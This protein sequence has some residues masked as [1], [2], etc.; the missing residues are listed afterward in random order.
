[1][2]PSRRLECETL[3][4]WLHHRNPTIVTDKLPGMI[5]RTNKQ[6]LTTKPKPTSFTQKLLLPTTHLATMASNPQ[7]LSELEKDPR[8]FLYTSLT[9]GSSHIVTATSRIETILRANR[10]PFAYIDTATNEKA[11]RLWVRRAG[12]RKLPALVKDG[13]VIGV[14]ELPLDNILL[15]DYTDA[16][17]MVGSRP[18]RR[19][20]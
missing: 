20:E 18:S 16:G 6:L 8:L 2:R 9:A 12:G 19:M 13:F 17:G 14:C 1:M 11:K 15:N 7:D 10:V 3:L 5:M 4:V